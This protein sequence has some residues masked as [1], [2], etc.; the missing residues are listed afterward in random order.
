MQTAAFP[1]PECTTPLRLRD[2]KLLGRTISCPDC[3]KELKIVEDLDGN[4]H[5]ET[6][7]A[8][9]DSTQGIFV[10]DSRSRNA[11]SAKLASRVA[12][13][14]GGMLALGL[15][16]Y[17][18][19]GSRAADSTPIESPAPQE[20]TV[21]SGDDS[22]EPVA[23]VEPKDDIEDQDAN[24]G[25]VEDDPVF[26]TVVAIEETPDDDPATRS[27]V[28]EPPVTPAVPDAV[29]E[30][31]EQKDQ[32]APPPVGVAEVEDPVRTVVEI[33]AALE[34]SIQT[35]D[36]SEPAKLMDLV[37]TVCEA[38]GADLRF[39]RDID[40]ERRNAPTTLFVEEQTLGEILAILLNDA[41]MESE[42][43]PGM[44]FIRDRAA[45]DTPATETE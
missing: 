32:A 1:C 14:V 3:A 2:R 29:A 18:W 28:I 11:D 34:L 13:V 38:A 7:T 5:A 19:P 6:T 31:A 42:I 36:Q 25:E 43:R 40:D 22:A 17:L 12:A 30:A 4:L 39:H 37:D 10:P 41:G 21:V 20:P 33:E 44:I 16:L 9:A 26:A 15:L 27:A 35:W 24:P 45:D 8:V 23:A